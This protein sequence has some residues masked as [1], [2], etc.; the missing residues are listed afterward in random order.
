MSATFLPEVADK[1]GWDHVETLAHLVH[2][3]GYDGPLDDALLDSLS[4]TRYQSSYS[5]LSY[6]DYSKLTTLPSIRADADSTIVGDD[7]ASDTVRAF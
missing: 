7:S 2:K 5:T 4:L 6:D 1:E 3:A